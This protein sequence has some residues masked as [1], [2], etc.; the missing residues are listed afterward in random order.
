MVVRGWLFVNSCSGISLGWPL[1]V[2]FRSEAGAR[3]A[4]RPKDC[5]ILCHILIGHAVLVCDHVMLHRMTSATAHQCTN[6]ERVSGPCGSKFIHT[7]IYIYIYIH[8][9]YIYTTIYIYIYIYI[10]IYI[11]IYCIY[12]LRVLRWVAPAEAKCG[13]ML[14]WYPDHLLNRLINISTTIFSRYSCYDN[15]VRDSPPR[16]TKTKLNLKQT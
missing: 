16:I 3:C 13:E 14:R 15:D 4:Q 12:P 1:D 7:Y 6:A 2:C 11:Y 10:H 9:S 8:I 5:T